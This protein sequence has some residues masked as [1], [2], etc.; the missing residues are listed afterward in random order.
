[1]EVRR[2]TKG[3]ISLRIRSKAKRT[4][5]CFNYRGQKQ[6]LDSHSSSLIRVLIRR[7]IHIN[8]VCC[9]IMMFGN[10]AYIRV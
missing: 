4:V 7:T 3:G 2:K 1:M 8:A 6:T 5:C 10:Q 9:E